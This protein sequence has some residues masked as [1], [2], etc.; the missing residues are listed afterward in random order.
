LLVG[1]VSS[2]DSGIFTVVLLPDTQKYAESYPETYLAQT[3]WIRERRDADNIK[4]V[5]HLGDIV[6]NA[7]VDEE[8]KSADRAHQVLDG[9]VPYSMIPGNHDLDLA[10][11]ELTRGTTMYDEYFGPQRFEKESWYGGNM[12]GSNAN[13]YCLF[14]ASGMKFMVL[15]LEWAPRQ[16]TI[17]WASAILKS[18]RDHRVI[19]ATHYHMRTEHR[20][21][22]ES[23]S[24][25]IGDQL[26]ERLIRRHENIFMVVSGHISGVFRQVSKNDA[27]GEV[28]EIL[29]D[30]Q[31]LPNGGDGWLQTLR[32]VPAKNEIYV[33][34]YSPVLEKTQRAKPHSYRF[35]YPMAGAA[36]A[37]R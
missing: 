1:C 12:D 34:A 36:S 24:G 20:A 6:Q 8:W 29:C 7:M 31:S 37:M 35:D 26:W 2:P 19:L 32:F 3:E 28:H 4:F 14:E 10:D 13:N 27:G 5:I 25:Y 30:Y 33:D 15:G 22:S 9:V 16:A 17:D 21:D 11:G 18:H 23:L